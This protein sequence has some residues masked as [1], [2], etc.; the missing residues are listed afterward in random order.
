MPTTPPIKRS[1][2][3]LWEAV[4]A[5]IQQGWNDVKTEFMRLLDFFTENEILSVLWTLFTACQVE[6]S[7]K[8]RI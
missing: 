1:D 4:M 5:E 6:D 3:D 2:D 8:T 7:L